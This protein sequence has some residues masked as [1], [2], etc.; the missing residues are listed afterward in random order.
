MDRKQVGRVGLSMAI[1]YFTNKG[2]TILIPLNDT[3]WYDLV[4]E[5]M[6]NSKPFN[7]K[8]LKLIIVKLV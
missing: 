1:N 5:K 3:Q 6:E 2:Y 4:I 8:L 7:V